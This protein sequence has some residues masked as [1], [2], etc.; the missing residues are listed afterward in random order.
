M[1][2][3]N[4]GSLNV[5][6]IEGA[7]EYKIIDEYLT[8]VNDKNE[9]LAIFDEANQEWVDVRYR[10]CFDPELIAKVGANFEKETGMTID[11]AYEIFSDK[12]EANLMSSAYDKTK[13]THLWRFMFLGGTEFEVSVGHITGMKEDV[14]VCAYVLNKFISEDPVPLVVGGVIN[15]QS[16]ASTL[17]DAFTDAVPTDSIFGFRNVEEMRTFIKNNI[18]AGSLVFGKMLTLSGVESAEQ[19]NFENSGVRVEEVAQ[20]VYDADLLARIL[21]EYTTNTMMDRMDEG[22]IGIMVSDLGVYWGRDKILGIDEGLAEPS[23]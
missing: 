13:G 10:S 17:I 19:A 15:G 18:P 8:A 12:H 20:V 9:E 11:E 3:G 1:M 22:D 23:E 14:V 16:Y 21:R 7:T 4:E 5:L 2:L 6:E